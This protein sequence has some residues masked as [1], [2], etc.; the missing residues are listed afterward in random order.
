MSERA[1]KSGWTTHRFDELATMITDRI[2]D[3][4]QAAVDRYV[5]L[6]HLDADSLRITRWG[7]PSD[8]EATKLIFRKGDIIF[9]RRRAYQRKLAVASFD[10]ICSAHAMVLRP[11]VDVV[12]PEFLPFFMQSDAF[13]SRANEISVG[14]L[15]PTVNW[16]ALAGQEFALPPLEEQRRVASVLLAAEEL[17]R[18]YLEAADV[19]RRIEPSVLSARRAGELVAVG[20]VISESS[21]GCSVRATG[22]STGVPILRIPNVLRGELDLTDLKWVKL[23]VSD[24]AR[25][26]LRESDILVVRTNGNPDYVGRCLVVPKL[27]TQT[28]YASYLIRLVPDSSRVRSE[29]LVSVMN[30]VGV[31]RLMRA[32]I[33]SSAGNYNINTGGLRATQIVLPTLEQQDGLVQELTKLRRI[34][35]QFESRAHAIRR[36]QE[37]LLEE[38][39]A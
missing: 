26:Q 11:K 35:A 31:R 34:T 33:R 7:V 28:V 30:S 27:P 5:G 32:H 22:D 13:M 29:Y 2:A 36:I 6:E 19:A 8:V 17:R 10:G 9:G 21:Y 20:D 14:S 23:S 39:A 15:S 1:S 3:P 18:S 24:A 16:Q 12:L 4:S 38:L 25:Y 37:L